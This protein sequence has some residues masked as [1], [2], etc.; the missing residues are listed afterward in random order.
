MTLNLKLL[1]KIYTSYYGNM[2]NLDKAGILPVSI[3]LGIP[4]WFKGTR[5][6]YL[7]PTKKMLDPKIPEDQYVKM[8]KEILGKVSISTLREDIS[9]ITRRQDIDIALLC[10]EKPGDFCHRHLFAEWMKEQ[11]GYEIE[12]FGIKKQESIP[13]PDDMQQTLF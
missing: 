11:T 4:K 13:P 6:S 1:M 2:R 8:Y 12:E 3:S 5:L 10:W 7:A 9:I